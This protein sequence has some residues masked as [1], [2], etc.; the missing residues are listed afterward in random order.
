MTGLGQGWA[1]F[2][3]AMTSLVS[4]VS[5]FVYGREQQKKERG[6][7]AVVK[8]KI[9]GGKTIE[10]LESPPPRPPGN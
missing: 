7:K 3:I 4:L 5:V 1:G 9:K 10:D 8:E 6:E 2:G